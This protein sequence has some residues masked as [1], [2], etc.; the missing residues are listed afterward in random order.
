MSRAAKGCASISF[1]IR[2]AS[3]LISFHAPR[4][5]HLQALKLQ[6]HVVQCTIPPSP[7]LLSLFRLRVPDP[8]SPVWK[9]CLPSPLRGTPP[10]LPPD[11]HPPRTSQSPT[12]TSA[13]LLAKP[14]NGL[15][16]RRSNSRSSTT[17]SSPA[18]QMARRFSSPFPAQPSTPSRP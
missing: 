9:T 5:L 15:T 13:T 16:S 18:S 2:E 12:S 6:L 10:E 11:S 17:A 7:Y 3:P 1:Y 14:V 4:P 8:P